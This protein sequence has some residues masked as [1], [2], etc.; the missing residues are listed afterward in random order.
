MSTTAKVERHRARLRAEGLRPFQMWVPDTR[1]PQFA[2]QITRQ[3]RKLKSDSAEREILEF[4]DDAAN[5]T[6]GWL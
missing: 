5:S 1:T 3:V 6:E 4:T 2:E